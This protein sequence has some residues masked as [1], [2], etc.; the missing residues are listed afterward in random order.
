MLHGISESN[1]SDIQDVKQEPH[2][3]PLPYTKMNPSEIAALNFITAAI[4]WFDVLACASKSTQPHL[5]NYY[6][7]ISCVDRVKTSKIELHEIM[8][9][10]NWAMMT[11]SHIAELESSNDRGTSDQTEKQKSLEKGG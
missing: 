6:N 4:I 5:Y 8:G 1:A 11:I 7:I 9:C 10:Q 3:M 2:T